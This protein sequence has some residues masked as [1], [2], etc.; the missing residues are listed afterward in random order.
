ME[1]L[2]R[3]L[4]DTFDYGTT[5]DTTLKDHELILVKVFVT[6]LVLE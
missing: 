4:S 5:R 3:K 2:K 1:H 6:D